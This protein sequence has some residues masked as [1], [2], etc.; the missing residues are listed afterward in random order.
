MSGCSPYC[1]DRYEQIFNSVKD[2]LV[3]TSARRLAITAATYADREQRHAKLTEYIWTEYYGGVFIEDF[4]ASYQGEHRKLL[5]RHASDEV[6]HGNAFAEYAGREHPSPNGSP[7]CALSRDTYAAYQ[8]W[9][10]GDFDA[11]IA[12]IHVLELRTAMILTQWFQLLLS[13]PDDEHDVIRDLL[14]RIARDE[15]FHLTYTIQLLHER[16]SDDR[17]AD[18]LEQAFLI[19]EAGVAE[20]EKAAQQRASNLATAK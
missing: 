19:S 12:I 9:V 5:V 13:Y 8:K 14:S 18:L 7:E 17:V 15:V 2:R 3:W 4:L 20:I 16:L 6:R 11:F 10:A 1:G